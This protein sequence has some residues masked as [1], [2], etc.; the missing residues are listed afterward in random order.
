MG[1]GGACKGG[2][3]TR[4]QSW[5]GTSTPHRAREELPRISAV[6]SGLA[7]FNSPLCLA[8]QAVRAVQLRRGFSTNCFLITTSSS[9]PWKTFLTPSR[10]T[11]KWPSPSWPTWWVPS[12]QSFPQHCYAFAGGKWRNFRNTDKCR[13]TEIWPFKAIHLGG[14]HFSH[15]CC[16]CLCEAVFFLEVLSEPVYESKS[17][18]GSER[19]LTSWGTHCAPDA[20]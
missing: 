10:C 5:A 13:S 4:M 16:T 1:T 18:R 3:T 11:L 2:D 12:D 19:Q 9:G 8:S 14:R 17:C 15:Q 7:G 6:A 20:C